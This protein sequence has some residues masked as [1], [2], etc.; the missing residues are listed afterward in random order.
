MI[1]SLP[2]QTAVKVFEELVLDGISS[3]LSNCRWR[4]RIF[5]RFLK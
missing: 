2:V 4:D 3:W 1:I 5:R